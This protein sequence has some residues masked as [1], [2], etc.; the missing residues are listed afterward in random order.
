MVF[1]PCSDKFI[2]PDELTTA[3]KVEQK[4]NI[5][6]GHGTLLYINPGQEDTTISQCQTSCTLGWC[7]Y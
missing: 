1:A 5:P 6:K 4:E 3:E 7:T 2:G